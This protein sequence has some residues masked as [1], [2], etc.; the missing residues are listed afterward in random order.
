MAPCLFVPQR[1]NRIES[2][3]PAGRN[4]TRTNEEAQDSSAQP[5]QRRLGGAT[6]TDSSVLPTAGEGLVERFSVAMI[7]LEIAAVVAGIVVLILGNRADKW[8][9]RAST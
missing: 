1:L 5:E 8:A 9:A 3:C 6:P 7:A 2:Y 4:G